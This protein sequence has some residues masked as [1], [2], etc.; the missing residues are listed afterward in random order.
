MKKIIELDK[1]SLLKSSKAF[2]NINIVI[3]DPDTSIAGLVKKVLS[4]LGCNL[5]FTVRDGQSVLDL[6][7]EEK[8]DLIITDWQTKTI[9]GID[10]TIHLR[11]SLDSPNRTIPII[12]LTGH[13]TREDIQTAR[14]AGVTEYISK[15]FTAKT[16]LERLYDIVVDPRGF[17]ICKSFTGPDRRRVS[18]L[19]LP[20]LDSEKDQKVFERKSPIIVTADTLQQII[21]DDTPRM[22][23]PDYALRK[24]VGLEIPKDLLINPLTMATSQDEIEKAK[25]EFMTSIMSDVATMQDTYLILIKSPDNARI[26]VKTIQE[27]AFSIKARAGI[28]GYLRATEVA[29]QLYTFCKKYYDRDNAQHLIIIE[30]HIQTIS[31]IFTHKISGDGG[32]VGK[33]LILDL[34][35][36]ISK[37]LNKQQ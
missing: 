23:M 28:F 9:S 37:Y 10:L 27:T 30:K 24:K 29:N 12:M 16:L 19:T 17:I 1:P 5:I 11:Q 33:Q 36:L 35:R 20:L 32:E 22:I 4:T 18:S 2:A 3:C 34:A 13:N 25:N 8:I 7:R 6:L 31:A 15:P 14:D 21:L 26:L